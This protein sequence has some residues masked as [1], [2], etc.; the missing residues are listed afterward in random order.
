MNIYEILLNNLN[1]QKGKQ[2]THTSSFVNNK[3]AKILN[4]HTGEVP[5]LRGGAGDLGLKKTY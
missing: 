1:K 5:K 3:L 2:Q 4:K